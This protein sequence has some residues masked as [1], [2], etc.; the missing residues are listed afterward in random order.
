MKPLYFI[1]KA[2]T[3]MR[4]ALF[5]NILAAANIALS[6]TL[7]GGFLV[8]F[9]NAG[10]IAE[11]LGNRL[12]VT[13]Y[14]KDGVAGETLAALEEEI[15]RFPETKGVIYISKE[16]ALTSLKKEL[17]GDSSV[18]DGLDGNPLPASL[19][20]KLKEKFQ[21]PEGIK[22]VTG[23]LK[24]VHYIN[25]L[26]YGGEWMDRFSTL[27]STVKLGGMI[28]GIVL[29][30]STMLIVSN[31]IRLTIQTRM[32]EI[33]VMR[34]VGATPMFIKIPFFIEGLI[35]G[36]FGAIFATVTMIGV[37]LLMEY[38]FGSSMKLL[39]GGNIDLLPYQAVI[40]LFSFGMA[41]GLF[42]SVISLWRFPKT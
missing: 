20:I 26:Q 17:G 18:L 9:V 2:L 36:I 19:T 30:L 21:N 23:R 28:F 27:L 33:D 24:G 22:S 32:D 7:F 8:A 3:G 25:D 12:E 5:V 29:M 13:A 10:H 39:F 37:K 15:K 14:L 35:L 6:L 16:E 1:E 4:N 42:G 34:L 41:F 31:T 11:R 38:N 40:G